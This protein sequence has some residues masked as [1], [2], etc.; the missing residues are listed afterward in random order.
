[1]MISLIAYPHAENPEGGLAGFELRVTL[2]D[3]L[4]RRVYGRNEPPAP[5]AL[6]PVF[7]PGSAPGLPFQLPP[8]TR[9][10]I[11]NAV[12]STHKSIVQFAGR[13][14]NEEYSSADDP[15]PEDC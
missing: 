10:H 13:L 15:V 2:V 5:I 14:V 8:L 1:M 4:V 9:N 12:K 6:P 7:E 11:S 3:V